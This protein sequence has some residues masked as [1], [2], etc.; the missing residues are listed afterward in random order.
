MGQAELLC[1]ASIWARRR[2]GAPLASLALSLMFKLKITRAFFRGLGAIPA[3]YEAAYEALEAGSPLLIFPGG[4]HETLRP[5][6]QARRVDFGGHKG[7]LRI[8]R[9][10]GVPI[11]PMGI[12]GG[13]YTAPMLLRAGWLAW[14]LIFP[15]LLGFKRWGLSL[16]GALGA[17]GLACAPLPLIARL[18]L[19]PLWLTSP[20]V[21]T[22]IVPW[23]IRFRVGAP[24]PPDALFSG[25][26]DEAEL[27]QALVEVEARV[28]A[29][30]LKERINKGRRDRSRREEPPERHQP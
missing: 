3:T 10:A 15:R 2:P 8:A 13:H 18:A 9:Q 5:I 7:F 28:A 20:L 16:L 23:T 1:F 12:R 27:E 6:W 26:G 22:P 25:A 19:I 4:A 11:I 24:I 29:L 14:L 21:F 17:L 30:T